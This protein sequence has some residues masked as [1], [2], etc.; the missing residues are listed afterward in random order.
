MLETPLQLNNGH[1]LPSDVPMSQLARTHPRKTRAR[2]SN[3]GK[4]GDKVSNSQKAIVINKEEKSEP[5]QKKQEHIS[6]LER[7]RNCV[8]NDPNAFLFTLVII[9]YLICAVIGFIRT[10]N[11][12]MLETLLPYASTYVGIPRVAP[13]LPWNKKEGIDQQN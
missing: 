12:S 4:R 1:P 8:P 3:T 10:G 2:S 11:A 7:L 13:L 5:E 9:A 6:L